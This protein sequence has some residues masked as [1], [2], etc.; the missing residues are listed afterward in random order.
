MKK[1]IYIFLIILLS[2]VFAGCE[3]NLKKI[4]I[5]EK[6]NIYKLTPGSYLTSQIIAYKIDTEKIEAVKTKLIITEKIN[7]VNTGKIEDFKFQIY[8]KTHLDEVNIDIIEFKKV[9][10]IDIYK[11]NFMYEKVKWEYY[12]TLGDNK[13]FMYTNGDDNFDRI[14]NTIIYNDLVIVLNKVS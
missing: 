4:R 2:F 1:I 5:N 7:G 12:L 8:L 9:A 14:E 10:G 6:E 3:K 13:L 11:F